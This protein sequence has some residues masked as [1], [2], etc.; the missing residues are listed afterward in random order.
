MRNIEARIYKHLLNG[1]LYLTVE[2]DDLTID[3]RSFDYRPGPGNHTS[4]CFGNIDLD[5]IKKISKCIYAAI[6]QETA[7][8]K[9]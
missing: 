7:D 5:E 9:E 2:A 6:C 1:M 3:M 8:Q 4:V